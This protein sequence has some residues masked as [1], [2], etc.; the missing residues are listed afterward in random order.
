MSAKLK[1]LHVMKHSCIADALWYLRDEE[2]PLDVFRR[3]SDTISK[4]LI[5]E[6]MRDLSLRAETVKTPLTKTKAERLSEDV[7][8]VPV[9]RAGLAMLFGVLELVPNTRVGFVGLERDEKTA[10]AK[11][12]YWKIPTV[13]KNTVV[14]VVDPML[15]TGGSAIHVLKRIA[16]E[17][18]KKLQ[19]VSV[20]AAPEGIKAVNDLFPDVKIFTAAVDEKLNT[21]K[22]IVPGL[23]DYG[24]RYFGTT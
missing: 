17:K 16:A 20:I 8:V 7:L 3:N 12:Y 2:T 23:G 6:A 15:A 14:M 5:A 1:N 13:T 9:L 19:L 10:I 24:D 4:L 21:Q 18:P 11:E 22:Y